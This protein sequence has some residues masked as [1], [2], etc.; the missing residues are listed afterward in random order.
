[1]RMS[2]PKRDKI[3]GNW[4]KLDNEE[5]HN[6]Y[7]TPNI[8]RMLNSR[9]TK[10]AGHVPHIRISEEP[11]Q[12]RLL[13]R[14]RSGWEDN[15]TTRWGSMDWINVAQAKDQWRALVNTVISLRFR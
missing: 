14:Q 2:G 6:S 5:L 8:I 9:T 13:R 15:T 3:V 4:R 7:S 1:M 10:L 11:E 12:K